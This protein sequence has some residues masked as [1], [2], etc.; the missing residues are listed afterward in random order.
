MLELFDLVQ[1]WLQPELSFP[2]ADGGNR[3]E[4]LLGKAAL[5]V[6]ITVTITNNLSESMNTRSSECYCLLVHFGS[7]T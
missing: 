6:N 1:M 4:E 3:C 7:S 5:I 2:K